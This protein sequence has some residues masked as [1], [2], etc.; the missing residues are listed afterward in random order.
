[1][2]ARATLAS[3]PVQYVPRV[4]TIIVTVAALMALCR[5]Q[6]RRYV[7]ANKDRSKTSLHVENAASNSL[8]SSMRKASKIY[9]SKDLQMEKRRWSNMADLE[10]LGHSL[11][12]LNTTIAYVRDT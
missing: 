1:M 3:K 9:R 10:A 11:S 5:G 12:I 6:E 4:V 7:E 8:G 2:S